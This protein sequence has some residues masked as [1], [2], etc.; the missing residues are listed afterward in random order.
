MVSNRIAFG[1]TSRK[2][3]Q[4]CIRCQLG[5]GEIRLRH[6]TPLQA[7]G[8]FSK[9]GMDC[10]VFASMLATYAIEFGLPLTTLG[11][12][13]RCD[14]C[15]C[16]PRYGWVPTGTVLLLRH[17]PMTSTRSLWVPSTATKR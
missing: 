6:A 1:D 15:G 2:P 12:L 14:L 11:A 8:E 17:Q 3:T 10:G 9:N 7:D 13:N 16:A 5:S 4:G